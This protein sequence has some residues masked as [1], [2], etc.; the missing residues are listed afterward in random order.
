MDTSTVVTPHPV[1]GSFD[2]GA[3]PVNSTTVWQP[4]GRLCGV[5]GRK[6]LIEGIVG[7]GGAIAHFKVT[8]AAFQDGN[9]LQLMADTDFNTGTEDLQDA[10]PPNLYQTAAGATFQIFLNANG[11]EYAFYA[12]AASSNTT[13]QIRGTGH[14]KNE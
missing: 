13:L 14:G 7:A 11:H 12:Q 4:I 3:Q 6:I 2:T 10:I 9:H 1:D 5:R 8:R